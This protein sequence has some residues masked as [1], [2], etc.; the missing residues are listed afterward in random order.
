[1]KKKKKENNS[2]NFLSEKEKEIIELAKSRK[3]LEEERK[4]FIESEKYLKSK[5]SIGKISSLINSK[6]TT[7]IR[8]YSYPKPQIPNATQEQKM[9]QEMFS[10]NNN[11]MTGQNL[12][13]IDGVL[14]TGNGLI[15][16]GDRKKVTASFFGI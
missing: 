14:I 12:P 3:K 13:K 16:N 15:K 5:T 10:G 11:W 1:M 8:N 6:P 4:Q 9:L 2:Y 7:K